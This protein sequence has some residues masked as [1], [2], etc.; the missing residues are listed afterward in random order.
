LPARLQRVFD[1][2]HTSGLLNAR[3]A[4]E[5]VALSIARFVILVLMA[6]EATKAVGVEV[7]IWHLAAAMPFVIFSSVIAISPGALGVSE[8]TYATALNLFGTPLP[9][10]AQ[11]AI[12]NRFL[13]T[14]ASFIVAILG[15]GIPFL[16]RILGFSK[17]DAQ[18]L[19]T[20]PGST[21]SISS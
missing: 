10:A 11:F 1:E 8:L 17:R 7:P 20:E 19:R 3:L 9:I 6:Y 4:R 21:S 16:Q 15:A 18:F 13:V 2:L 14:A 5:L 12:A